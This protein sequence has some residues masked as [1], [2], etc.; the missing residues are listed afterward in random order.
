MNIDPAAGG[1]QYVAA[2]LPAPKPAKGTTGATGK[3]S[4][5]KPKVKAS[6]PPA[7][8]PP[9][10]LPPVTP[11]PPKS[12]VGVTDP[13]T[14]GTGGIET[15]KQITNPFNET[16]TVITGRLIA[17]MDRTTAPN[18]NREA[19]WARLR[20]E[21][22][23]LK[24]T[25][26]EAAH[27]WGPGFGDEAAA[28]MMLAPKEVNQVWQNQKAETF[29]RELR[30]LA[31]DGGYEVHVRAVARSHPREF[32]GGAGDALM[33]SVQ[34]DFSVSTPGGAKTPFGQITFEVGLPPGGV[35]S[36]PNVIMF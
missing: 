32:A 6:A 18:Y 22:P 13:R 21:H 5:A 9:P 11:G 20:A 1:Q 25:D 19:L 34:Y 28:G 33:Q 29:L 31:A 15:M 2:H 23:A 30:E 4:V 16:E 14:A 26:W 10:A 7:G 17:G 12:A 8:A 27:L 35:V 24:L 36:K 3:T